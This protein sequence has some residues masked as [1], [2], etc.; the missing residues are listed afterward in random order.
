M[1]GWLFVFDRAPNPDNA[2]LRRTQ[3]RSI[4]RLR[5]RQPREHTGPKQ[6]TSVVALSFS[7]SLHAMSDSNIFDIWIKIAWCRHNRRQH[8]RT[9]TLNYET[10]R[11]ASR[12]AKPENNDSSPSS[13]QSG[14]ELA[15]LG[16]ALVVASCGIT[17]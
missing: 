7:D 12:S 9:M 17:G 13:P 3:L 2:M 5:I 11:V 10:F 8:K 1:K 4:R 16:R 15:V 6:E 14:N